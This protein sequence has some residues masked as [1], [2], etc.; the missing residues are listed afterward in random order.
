L[1]MA[2]GLLQTTGYGAGAALLWLRHGRP[3]AASLDLAAR[4]LGKALWFPPFKIPFYGA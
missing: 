3:Q 4:G 1:W 2:W